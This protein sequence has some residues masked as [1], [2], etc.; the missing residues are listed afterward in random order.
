MHFPTISKLAQPRFF[1]QAQHDGWARY[2]ITSLLCFLWTLVIVP[3]TLHTASAAEFTPDSVALNI[4]YSDGLSLRDFTS[5][6]NQ[7]QPET[8]QAEQYF[9]IGSDVQTTEKGEYEIFIGSQGLFNLLAQYQLRIINTTQITNIDLLDT[10]AVEL[11][12]YSYNSD[13]ELRLVL[14]SYDGQSVAILYRGTSAS[15][16]RNFLLEIREPGPFVHEGERHLFQPEIDDVVERGIFSGYTEADGSKSFRPD[17]GINR[18]EFLKVIVLATPGVT[19]SAVQNF[20]QQFK[21]QI[22]EDDRI[23][24]DDDDPETN[25]LF[26]DVDREAWF[27]AYIFYA[28]DKGW[29]GGYPDG[30]FRPTNPINMAEAPKIILAARK[31]SFVPDSQIWFKPYMD[32]LNEKNVLIQRADQYRFSFT[33]VVFFPYENVTRAQ[34]AA[35]LSRLLWIDEYSDVDRFAQIKDPGALPFSFS[36]QLFTVYQMDR[37]LGSE[38]SKSSYL[39]YS[40]NDLALELL[41]FTPEQWTQRTLN[42][43]AIGEKASVTYLGESKSAV[44][45][46]MKQCVT[47]SCWGVGDR[48]DVEDQFTLLQDDLMAF[49]DANAGLRFRHLEPLQAKAELQPNVK[50]LQITRDGQ[51]MMVLNMLENSSDDPAFFGGDAA[52]ESRRIGNR[53]WYVY[54][55]TQNDQTQLRLVTSF[56]IKR[57]MVAVIRDINDF[58]QVSGKVLRILRTLERF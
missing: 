50:A 48:E 55:V 23:V 25:R 24:S 43:T 30:T 8:F 32:Y 12:G 34:T 9:L 45:A 31:L 37:S 16:F 7:S 13:D 15:A 38:R 52:Q 53:D 1:R 36:G 57:L 29:V 19:E 21:A 41:E 17:Q 10:T 3:W 42:G 35:L 18:A 54:T 44:Y 49:E 27:A 22:V 56:G 46:S 33:D 26:P 20:Y 58:S 6:F 14:F 11:T 2:I 28:Y 40:G 39:L 47:G 4:S 51:E 5:E